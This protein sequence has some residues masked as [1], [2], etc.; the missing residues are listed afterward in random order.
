MLEFI[1]TL[2]QTA[3]GEKSPDGRK[4]V[5]SNEVLENFIRTEAYNDFVMSLFTDTNKATNFFNRLVPKEITGDIKTPST[6][7]IVE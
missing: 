5:K 7:S 6:I 1:E 3:Y 4:F 2:V